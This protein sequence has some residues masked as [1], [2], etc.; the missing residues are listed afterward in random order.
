MTDDLAILENAGAELQAHQP[1]RTVGQIVSGRL[2]ACSP[3]TSVA[4]AARL[5]RS[6]HCSSIVVTDQGR[7]VGIWTE[8]DALALD[9]R[10]RDAFDQPIAAVMT[11]NVLSIPAET[12]MAEASLRLKS[13]GIRHLLVV[14]EAGLPVG[15]L[16]QT[17]VVQNHGVE[18]YLTFRDVR[19][20]MSRSLFTLPADISLAEG[21]RMIHEGEVDAAIVTSPDWPEPGIITE[22]D[23]V[24]MVS[25]RRTGRVGDAA[26]RPVVTV[27]PNSS[28]L[29]A[30]NLFSRHGFR[31]LAVRDEA[32]KFVGL[33]GFSDIMSILQHEYVTQLNWALRERDEALLRSHKDLHLARQ[34]IEAT[35][36]GVMIVDENGLIEYVN[37]AFTRLTGYLPTEVI[38]RNPRLLQS[39]L[40]NVEFYTRMWTEVLETGHW[41]GEIW[42]RR[43]TGD[44]FAERLT[45]NTIRGTDGRIV[46]FAAIFSDITDRKR[47]EEQVLSL[48][49]YDPLTELPNRRLLTDRLTQSISNA[50]RSG[51]K[52]ALMFLDLD[53][54]KGIN[55]TL[56]H[57]AGDAVLV[58][59]SKRLLDCVRDGDTVARLGGDEFVVL[60]PELRD[61]TDAARLASRLISQVKAP[62]YITGRQLHVT[63]SVGIALYP[64]DGHAP[65]VLLKRADTAMYQAK[66]IGRNNYQLHSAAM[67]SHS[68]RKLAMER[69]IR[70]AIANDEMSL[71]YQVKVDLDSGAISGAEALI[72]WT[73][74]E[75][76]MVPPGEFL[77][78]AERIGLMPAIGEWVL[79]TACRQ[80]RHW[81][82]RG[83]PAIRMAVN[84]SP[85]QFLQADLA[86][87]IISVLEETGMPP[88]LLEIELTEA[89]L[90][91]HPAEVGRILERLHG[92]GVRIAIDDFGTR[93]SSLTALR[94]LPIDVLKID[95]TFIDGL[96]QAFEERDIVTAI[97]HLAHALG[98]EAAAESVE[99]IH[100]VEI[101]RAAGCD[102]IQ[103]NLIGRAVSPQDLE[104]L[105]DRQLLPVG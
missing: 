90:I 94:L 41:E 63:T 76:G 9:F 54:F 20:V 47:E 85:Q 104:A 14:D 30:R 36:D 96:G 84:L 57:D 28:L 34:V 71:V 27:H 15:M 48:A 1:V 37:P 74:P 97:I 102:E 101:L 78:V 92:A 40:Q 95:H 82:E 49:Y 33:L 67:N 86:D 79:R 56:G 73:H 64:D 88:Q 22:R 6:H 10:Q 18:R 66:Q 19:S 21:A 98:M 81:V 43:K 59:V 65:E 11:R 32:G 29:L 100:Q 25:E 99:R 62:M 52:L 31:H 12:S 42:N 24:R 87:T 80:N 93:Q 50:Y 83:L 70:D 8:R 55:D 61:V 2:L 5:M 69:E 91:D 44:I 51:T 17:D 68:A 7:A 53:L 72:R 45:I 16:T 105:F 75:F 77:P 103:G 39:G 38:G 46:K 4:E 3:G 58:E 13:E 35:I 26:T 60:M 89:A 23:I